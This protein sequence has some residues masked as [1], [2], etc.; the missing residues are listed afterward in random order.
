MEEKK[1]SL[2]CGEE[3]FYLESG[4]GDDLVLLHGNLS[5]SSH[6]VPLLKGLEDSY[7]V[8]APDMPGFGQSSYNKKRQDLL[9]YAQVIK[10]WMEALGLERA[11][12]IAW[13]LGG[14][15][16]LELG[17]ISSQDLVKD[18]VLIAPIG[19]RDFHFQP[20]S[21]IGD[22]IR[23]GNYSLE[24]AGHK[25]KSLFSS[26]KEGIKGPKAKEARDTEAFWNYYLYP[27]GRPESF[28]YDQ[29]LKA[30]LSQKNQKDI[31]ASLWNFDMTQEG[32]ARIK[33]VD[34]R[35]LIIHG[36]ED[37]VVDPDYSREIIR[38][39]GPGASGECLEDGGHFLFFEEYEQVLKILRNFLQIEDRN[40]P[41]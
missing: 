20:L 19:I 23:Q 9:S 41:L 7:R 39:I 37:L 27:K 22:N 1:I 29:Y 15:I 11:H 8:L 30:S 6:M 24:G 17:A 12:L 5:S 3:I 10:E 33:E 26:I 16:A 35:V 34:Q 21:L 40:T 4:T 28:T 32:S 38:E 13:S 2:A 31:I 25:V 14:G 36:K 18:M